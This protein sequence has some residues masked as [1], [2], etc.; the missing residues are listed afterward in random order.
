MNLTIEEKISALFWDMSSSAR[1]KAVESVIND[2]LKAFNDD[3]VLLKALNTFSWY[4]LMQLAGGPENLVRLLDDR[5]IRKLFPE[6]RRKFYRDGKRLL[7][8]Y[9]ISPAG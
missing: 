9:I 7:S 1:K 5:I 6:S 4:E 2:P 3:S 8:K